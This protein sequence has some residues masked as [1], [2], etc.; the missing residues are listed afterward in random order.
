MLKA[1][2]KSLEEFTRPYVVL[3]GVQEAGLLCTV[4]CYPNGSD[5]SMPSKAAESSRLKDAKGFVNDKS[6]L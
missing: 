3:G 2:N 4:D 1:V 6:G 5:R